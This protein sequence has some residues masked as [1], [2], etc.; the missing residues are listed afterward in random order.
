[1]ATQEWTG[2]EGEAS[3]EPGTVLFVTEDAVVPALAD[4]LDVIDESFPGY[5]VEGDADDEEQKPSGSVVPETY[6]ASYRENSSTGQSCGDFLAEWLATQT[7]DADGKL[8][9]SAFD[10][11]LDANGVER[12]GKWASLPQSG[13]KGWVGRYRMNG[14]QVLEKRVAISETLRHGDGTPVEHAELPAAIADLQAKHAKWLAKER[15]AIAAA[16]EALPG[17]PEAE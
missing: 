13:Q 12:V 1:V 5:P 4:I 9:V 15:K 8:D 7:L 2:D 10:A 6:R 14:R 17:K 11:I 3:T 16:E